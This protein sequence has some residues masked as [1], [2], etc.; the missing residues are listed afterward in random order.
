MGSFMGGVASA[1]AK[2]TGGV[3]YTTAPKPAS[4]TSGGGDD[5]AMDG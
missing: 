2:A 5:D 4:G 3:A 1:S